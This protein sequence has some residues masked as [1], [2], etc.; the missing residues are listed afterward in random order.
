MSRNGKIGISVLFILFLSAC[1]TF[2][3]GKL[4]YARVSTPKEK[5]PAIQSDSEVMHSNPGLLA[6]N[7]SETPSTSQHPSIRHEVAV[8][9]SSDASSFPFPQQKKRYREIVNE[10]YAIETPL[11]IAPDVI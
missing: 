10:S 5:A 11:R 8:R 2:H 1:G 3:S 4:T 9:T 6:E 7:V